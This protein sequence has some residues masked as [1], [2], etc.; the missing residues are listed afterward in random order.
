MTNLEVFHWFI[1]SIIKL[2]FL[3]SF[4]TDRMYRKINLNFLLP[5]WRWQFYIIIICI[6]VMY[7][8]YVTQQNLHIFV[9]NQLIYTKN[10]YLYHSFINTIIKNRRKNTQHQNQKIIWPVVPP[11]ACF[12][13]GIYP[14]FYLFIKNVNSILHYF[15]TNILENCHFR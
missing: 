3:K 13:S 11:A 8:V 1:S 9:C 6:Y 12:Y 15:K 10:M 5:S 7:I 14:I 4:L 2:L